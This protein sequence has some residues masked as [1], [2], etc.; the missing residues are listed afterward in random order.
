MPSRQNSSPCATRPSVAVLYFTS[1][2]TDGALAHVACGL[3]EDVISRLAQTGGLTVTSRHD[4]IP[5]RHREV[6]TDELGKCMGVGCVLRGA[7][8]T[9]AGS[10]KVTVRLTDTGSGRDLW[11]EQFERSTSEVFELP[12]KIAMGVVR[13]LGAALAPAEERELSAKRTG[14]PRAYDFHCRGRQFLTMRGRK[15]TEA[16][17]RMFE[18]AVASDPDFAVAYESMA[19]ACSGM[20]TYYDGA[21]VWLDRMSAAASKAL[22]LDGCLV[23]ARFHLGIVSLHRREHDRAKAALEEIVRMRPTYYE[24]YQ[25]LGILSDLTGDYDAAL[26]Y[27]HKSAEVKPC[28][29]EPWLYINMT[30]RRRGDVAAAMEAARK[31][32]EVGLKTLKVIPDDPVT[33]SRFC[34]VYMLFDESEKAHDALDRVLRTGI[35]DGLVLYNC[36]A[37]YALLGD[38]TRCV[39]CLRRA[40]SGGY[41]N[42][43]SWI[44][45]D[46][47]FD[48]VR[49]TAG[50]ENLLSEFDLRHQTGT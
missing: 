48:L 44:D 14:D 31:F 8:D 33:L 38:Q 32:L 7:V 9:A 23:E 45:T 28:S 26:V 18:S 12:P 40:L 2:D 10:V 13:S 25:W 43:R 49:E 20:Y 24:A 47:D 37:T 19:A 29:V 27:Y 22:D 35:E 42:V 50:F 6:D 34:V 11:H 41:K 17:I 5:L 30:H 3:T 21:E 4:V 39:D 46:P 36:A 15:H 16:A 1:T